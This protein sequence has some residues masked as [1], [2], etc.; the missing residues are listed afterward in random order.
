MTEL[1]KLDRNTDEARSPKSSLE[2]APRTVLYHILS[3]LRI[4]Q[5]P[6]VLEIV[7]QRVPQ[8][9]IK[10]WPIDVPP[11]GLL[12]LLVAEKPEVRTWAQ[13][14]ISLFSTAPVPEKRFS[15]M[16]VSVLQGIST[17][18]MSDSPAVTPDGSAVSLPMTDDATA[19]WAGY[20]CVL[21]YTPVP[22][23][24]AEKAPHL[25]VSR[26]VASHLHDTG[27]R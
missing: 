13:L 8:T 25:D 11:P 7:N 5:D 22:L 16:H 15:P 3:N 24:N 21:R 12:L 1:S 2:N 4:L 23:L 14:Q 26:I 17:R 9:L 20:L 27:N 10:E 6:Y 19:L 18:I